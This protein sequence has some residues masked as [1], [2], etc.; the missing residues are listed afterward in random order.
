MSFGFAGKA[1]LTTFLSSGITLQTWALDMNVAVD[2]QEKLIYVNMW[3]EI[4]AGDDEKFK[5]L[6]LPYLR[7]GHLVF[8]VN[9]F[10][11]GGNV[12]TAM[13]LGDQIRLLQ[14]RTVTADNEAFII[15]NQIVPS[16]QALCGFWEGRGGYVFWTP[17]RGYNWCTCESACFLVW[18]SGVKREGGRI[19]V[20]RFY[21]K[22][23]E[24]GNLPVQTAREIYQ[25]AQA[26]FRAYVT[27]LDVPATII[28][29]LFATDRYGM[30]FL[31]RPEVQLLN[32]TPYI[33]EMVYSK[34]GKSRHIPMSAA[35]NWTSTE[36]PVHVACY[37]TILKQLMREGA[38]NYL[39][40]LGETAPTIVETAPALPDTAP[41]R[42]GTKYWN[43]NG[44]SFR[45]EAEKAN[46][47]FVFIEP[48]E[49]L[50][51]VGVREGMLGFRAN[52]ERTYMKELPTFTRHDAEQSGMR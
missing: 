40:S 42:T 13:K 45:L 21:Y 4:E 27:K 36:D 14:T 6:I 12:A 2:S 52:A 34:C 25:N 5:S 9:I 16:N 48:R 35:N 37:R 1:L 26:E 22:G 10:S 15:D 41:M 20:H 32:S 29:R 30:Y 8:Q 43:H 19:G 31:T 50:K 18:A 17:V 33:E 46:R 3:G 38:T 51:E 7:S 11:L 23:N 47:R 49:G 24:F 28:D 39:A 44:S